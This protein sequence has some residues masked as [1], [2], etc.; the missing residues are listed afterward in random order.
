M[1]PFAQ[2][3]YRC[4][5]FLR[6]TVVSFWCQHEGIQGL[7]KRSM[8]QK[9][10]KTAVSLWNKSA[11]WTHLRLV[12]VNELHISRWLQRTF[13]ICNV[14][15]RSACLTLLCIWHMAGW[16]FKDLDFSI[17]MLFLKRKYYSWMIEYFIC[18]CP[19]AGKQRS[20]TPPVTFDFRSS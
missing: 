19:G 8:E 2:K 18:K 9:G 4:R 17:P 1:R 16:Y 14:L 11:Y 13:F 10:I 5:I 12:A 20:S 3:G 7:K 15:M 6:P